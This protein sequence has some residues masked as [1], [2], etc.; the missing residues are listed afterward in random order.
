MKMTVAILFTAFLIFA[1]MAGTTQET[2]ETQAEETEETQATAQPT[3]CSMTY[4]LKTWS[5]FYKSSRG[6]GTITCENG[7]TARVKLRLKGGGLTLGKGEIREGQAHFSEVLDISDLFGSYV[8]ASAHAGAVKS[9]DATVMTKGEVS[10][11]LTG[12]G[13]GMELGIAAGKFTIKLAD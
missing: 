4:N 7:Q 2:E 11:S 13:S 8:S 9:V 6:E 1:P 10:L 5:V 3:S 12:K